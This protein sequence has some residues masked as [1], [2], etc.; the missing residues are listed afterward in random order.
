MT[1]VLAIASPP[2]PKFDP[3]P[4]G[5]APVFVVNPGE[6]VTAITGMFVTLTPG[7]ARVIKSA[8]AK[9][10]DVVL[11]FSS[12]EGIH[13][14]WFQGQWFEIDEKSEAVIIDRR[15]SVWWV[16]IKNA[17][18]QTG[19]T[20]QTIEFDGIDRLG[21]PYPDAFRFYRMRE[22]DRR[23]W[24]VLRPGVDIK[25][26]VG[27]T[28]TFTVAE[29]EP[30]AQS[31]TH[32]HTQEQFNLGLEG[33]LAVSIGGHPVSL[34]PGAG[35]IVTPDAE[36]FVINNGKT[37]AKML[38]FQPIRRLDLLP[39]RPAAAYPIGADATPVAANQLFAT[40]FNTTSSDPA[41]TTEP[42]GYRSKTL[43][44]ATAGFTIFDI[45]ATARQPINLRPGGARSEQFF[46]VLSG[47]V[48]F[49]S[50]PQSQ[51]LGTGELLLVPQA[52]S[53]LQLR[54]LGGA[55]GVTAPARVLRF[56]PR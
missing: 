46:Y 17:Q 13:R 41:W 51:G 26:F 23:A 38:E 16:E 36:H 9:P 32:H 24:T 28:G 14:A 33:D 53:D 43:R 6:V 30:G 7:R 27:E 29:F 1:T 21:G 54:L 39:P 45:P 8:H 15:K 44:G 19:W 18:G 50:G 4:A 49:M 25:P 10:G 12:G 47:L 34:A 2:E 5:T 3:P 48:E 22:V 52:T 40:N 20:D 42:E 55:R 31:F 56:D 35:A 37:R 11:T